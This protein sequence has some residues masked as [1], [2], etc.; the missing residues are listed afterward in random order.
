MRLS[1]LKAARL[2]AAECRVAGN[3][4]YAPVGMTKWR[5][6][7]RLGSR[8]VGW[9]LSSWMDDDLLLCKLRDYLL[10]A[11]A[12]GFVKLHQALVLVASSL[13][14]RQLRGK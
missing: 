11:S 12:K 14:E 5:A 10:P 2:D 13:G 7:S 9:T 4:G 3:P 8:G 1:L 6:A